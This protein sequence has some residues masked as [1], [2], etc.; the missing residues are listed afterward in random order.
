MNNN[1]LFM[2]VIFIG[3]TYF[4]MFRPQM[5]Q[6]KQRQELLNNLEEGDKIVSIGGIHGAI[7]TLKEDSMTVEI[8]PNVRV[9]MLRTSVGYVVT[10][11]EE[12]NIKKS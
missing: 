7:I 2:F 4:L 11:E 10:D 9:Q 6:K 8:A 1:S 3:L 12:K 5:K